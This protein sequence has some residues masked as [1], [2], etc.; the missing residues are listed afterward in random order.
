MTNSSVY[1][2]T[3]FSVMV[4]ASCWACTRDFEA[5]PVPGEVAGRIVFSGDPAP[6]AAN[7]RL[8]LLECGLSTLADSQGLFHLAGVP[9]GDYTV[10][11]DGA[12]ADGT[13]VAVQLPASARVRGPA[14]TDLGTITLEAAGRVRGT[15]AMADGS[16]PLYAVVYAVGG[17]RVALVADDG[18]FRLDGLPAGRVMLGASRPGYQLSTLAVGGNPSS[19]RSV[20]VPAGGEAVVERKRQKRPAQPFKPKKTTSPPLLMLF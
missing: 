1:R 11:L 2:A 3:V 16:S 13:P 20:E 10:R 12:S 6:P 4:A 15:A 18:S 7:A 19:D 5:P 17:D 14:V 8:R 9:T